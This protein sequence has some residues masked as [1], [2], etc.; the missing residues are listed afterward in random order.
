MLARVP[1][2]TKRQSGKSKGKGSVIS[3]PR[4]WRISL[5]L[6]QVV[7]ISATRHTFLLRCVKFA[8]GLP[9]LL[10]KATAR[11]ATKDCFSIT[12][13]NGPSTIGRARSIPTETGNRYVSIAL[14]DA[15]QEARNTPISRGTHSTAF[16]P[17]RNGRVFGIQKQTKVCLPNTS[18][19]RG[20]HS[21]VLRPSRNGRVFAL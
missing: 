2:L 3:D 7:R 21:R 14:C 9:A 13:R 18:I 4:L 17:S 11:M 6:R 8:R 1:R 10:E 16:R 20:T 5:R 15:K 12:N 19:S